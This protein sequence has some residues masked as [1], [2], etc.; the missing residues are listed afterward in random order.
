MTISRTVLENTL[1][2]CEYVSGFVNS[3][4]EITVRCQIHDIIFTTKYE[5]IRRSDRKHH[6]C[7][8][9]KKEDRDKKW[10]QDRKI[11]K[12]S[13]CGKEFSRSTSELKKSKSGLFFC[14]REHKDLA[15]RS[16]SGEDFDIMRPSHYGKITKNYRKLAFNS[17]LHKCAVCGWDEDE[18][19]LE[20]H[21]IDEDH[22]NNEI[23]NLMILCPLCH[24]KLTSHKYILKDNQL[25]KNGEVS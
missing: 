10:E 12:C 23:E 19:I 1:N 17:Y 7:P 22:S 5:N 13:Y 4:S 25:I 16:I 6:I 3:K 24:R 2:T 14:C 11:L 20:V 21:H 18:D 8:L 9:C 15:Q